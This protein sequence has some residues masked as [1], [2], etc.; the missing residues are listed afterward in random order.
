MW[1]MCVSVEQLR[2]KKRRANK[3]KI[4]NEL[5]VDKNRMHCIIKP[6]G[7]YLT[8]YVCMYMYENAK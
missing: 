8:N 2:N 6:P 5:T 3:N 1:K 7:T 4:G